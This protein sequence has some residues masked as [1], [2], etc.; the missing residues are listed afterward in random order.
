MYPCERGLCLPVDER[1]LLVWTQ[2]DVPMASSG[3]HFYKEGKGIPHPIA[4]RR[5][6]GHGSW[7]APVQSILGLTKMNWNNDQLYDRIPITLQYASKLAATMKSM[8]IVSARPYELRLF[9]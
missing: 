1:E 3:K 8:P 7:D 5:F 6:A 9:I 4:I 2:G